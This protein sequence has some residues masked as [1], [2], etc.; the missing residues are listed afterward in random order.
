MVFYQLV[1]D[2]MKRIPTYFVILRDSYKVD[3]S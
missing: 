3:A 2:F 1:R